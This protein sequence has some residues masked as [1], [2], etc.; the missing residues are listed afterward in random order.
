MKP[1]LKVIGLMSGTSTDGLDIALV[2][3]FQISNTFNIKPIYFKTYPYDNYIRDRILS[4]TNNNTSYLKD[5]SQINNDLGLLFANKVINFFKE[6]NIDKES[7]DLISSHGHTF[8]HYVDNG[9]TKSTLQ[10]A[11]PSIIANITDITTVGDFR[12]SDVAKEGQGAPLVPFFDYHFFKNKSLN[13]ALQNIGGISNVCFID[14]ENDYLTA[15][16]TGPGNIILDELIKLITNKKV[17]FDKDGIEASKG[18]LEKELFYHLLNDEYFTIKPPKTTGREKFG[19][20]YVKEKYNFAKNKKIKDSDI[21]FTFNYF[22][23]YSIY[24]SY[25][26]FLPK[27]PD[28]IVLSGGGA[29][30]KT[31]KK[32]LENLFKNKSEVLLIDDFGISSDSKEAIAFALLGYCTVFGISNNL[33]KATGSKENVIMGKICPA[34]NF[35]RIIFKYKEQK[36]DEITEKRNILS[37]D[38]DKLSPLEIVELMNLLDYDTI[39][40]VEKAKYQIAKVIEMTINTIENKHK[41]FYIGAGTSGR[42]GILDAVECPPTFRTDYEIVQGIIAG[43]NS[44]LFKAIEGAEDSFE[45]GKIDV[46]ERVSAG[47]ILIGISAN[48]KAKYVLSALETA[49][50]LN[51]KTVLITCNNVKKENYIDELIVINTGTEVLSGST[52]LKA[53][54]ATKMVL[55]MIST[56][57][58]AK[59]GK[60]YKNY[61]VDLNVSN[62]KLK[63]RAINILKDIAKVDD[64]IAE[65]FLKKS[66]GDV[67]V[68]L[69]MIMKGISEK[70]AKELLDLNKGFLR[71][72]IED[73]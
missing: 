10:L 34:K 64:S 14:Y 2:D 45:N 19:Y 4:I 24:K 55:N 53:G 67:K 5:I 65:D 58:F 29:Y 73:Y 31:L 7:I 68:A 8:Y 9:K 50:K 21:L 63:R 38:L 23:A 33:P 12:V 37:E 3:I 16:D 47:D 13:I 22:V 44:A 26:D 36:I 25:L 15:F 35:N 66:N 49:K 51:C 56:G 1:L 40:A 62:Q 61:M 52:R 46:Q 54:T 18:K 42:L 27:L 41:I 6:F 30:N 48:G 11:D 32:N 20:E 17:N 57:T 72:I 39:L 69:L 43:G 70:K 71:K 60:V 28:K 59:T